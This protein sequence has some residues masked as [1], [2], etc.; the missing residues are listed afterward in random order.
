MEVL[1]SWF[2]MIPSVIIFCGITLL[3][4]TNFDRNASL[5]N[6]LGYWAIY[7]II[8]LFLQFVVY[9]NA[10]RNKAIVEKIDKK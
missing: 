1:R 6:K 8:M 10:K 5:E 7:L 3:Y 4:W 9:V 2:F